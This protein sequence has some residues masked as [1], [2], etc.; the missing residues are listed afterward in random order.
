MH[1]RTRPREAALW[2][3]LALSVGLLIC[4][5]CRVRGLSGSDREAG[6]SPSDRSVP[7]QRPAPSRAVPPAADADPGD[8]EAPFPSETG[9]AGHSHAARKDVDADEVASMDLFVDV[10]RH[11]ND[12]NMLVLAADHLAAMGTPEACR[13]LIL[14]AA[15]TEKPDLYLASIEKISS[16]HAQE[17]LIGAAYD[18]SLPIDVRSAAVVALSRQRSR[19][20]QT[21]LSNLVR[22]ETGDQLSLVVVQALNDTVPQQADGAAGARSS[23]EPLEES[24]F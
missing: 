6:P 16:S 17:T 5:A 10:L 2:C 22:A 23:A 15:A 12:E 8:N 19:R 14:A 4:A 1:R 11:S 21:V 7:E 9:V 3:C 20:V 18:K 13:I 24:W